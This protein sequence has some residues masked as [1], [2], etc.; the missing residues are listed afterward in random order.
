[1]NGMRDEQEISTIRKVTCMNEERRGQILATKLEAPLLTCRTPLGATPL[2]P[3]R[4]RSGLRADVHA[5][6]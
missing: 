2:T 4:L 6:G 5:R 3:C 1:M